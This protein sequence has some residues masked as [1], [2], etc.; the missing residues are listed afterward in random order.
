M[1]TRIKIKQRVLPSSYRHLETLLLIDDK[2]ATRLSDWIVGYYHCKQCNAF[3]GFAYKLPPA[4]SVQS[5]IAEAHNDRNEFWRYHSHGDGRII[6][7]E[8][9]IAASSL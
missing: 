7:F 4:G 1:K 6:L 9:D 5:L 8:K 3:R 2:E